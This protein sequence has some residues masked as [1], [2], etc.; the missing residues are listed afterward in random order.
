MLLNVSGVLYVE[1]ER[2][3][4]VC[5]GCLHGHLTVVDD[6]TSI[7]CLVVAIGGQ[8]HRGGEG[9]LSLV[10]IVEILF[11]WIQKVTEETLLRRL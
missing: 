6:A 5:H 9:D 11:D 7:T 2:L 10:H 8:N 4:N 3:P 1:G